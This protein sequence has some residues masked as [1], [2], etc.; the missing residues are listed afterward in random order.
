MD[1]Q[2]EPALLVVGGDVRSS[3]QTCYSLLPKMCGFQQKIVNHAWKWESVTPTQ[4]YML[5]MET[6]FEGLQ[7][8]DLA[9]SFHGS[10]YV[11]YVKRIKETTVK[12]RENKIIVI[13]QRG[14][15]NKEIQMIY[16]FQL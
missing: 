7:M 11:K 2:Q 12:E 15:I 1:R 3:T 13:H 4:K 5:A 10:C 9:D 6:A 14:S 8:L 16:S